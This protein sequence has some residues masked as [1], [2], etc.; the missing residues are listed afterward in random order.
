MEPVKDIRLVDLDVAASAPSG[1]GM[2]RVVFVVSATPPE[3][4]V[5]VFRQAA[6]S[7]GIP[8]LQAADWDGCCVGV[9][10]PADGVI[11]AAESFK[12]FVRDVSN[13]YRSRH[14]RELAEAEALY[15]E[16]ATARFLIQKM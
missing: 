10:C 14:E 5:E 3:E 13:A 12:G 15:S 9:V 4:W 2:C 8:D 7:R 11:Q 1:P 6:E 16:L